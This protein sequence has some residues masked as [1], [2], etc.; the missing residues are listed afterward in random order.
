MAR[1]PLTNTEVP[2]YRETG[3]VA[4]EERF[5]QDESA[6]CTLQPRKKAQGLNA[7]AVGI[8][9]GE[10]GSVA[11]RYGFIPAIRSMQYSSAANPMFA[12]WSSCS[13]A[14]SSTKALSR[15]G[16]SKAD[17]VT[18]M[19]WPNRQP[20]HGQHISRRTN[21]KEVEVPNVK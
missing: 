12:L 5:D 9:E 4:V 2:Q 1:N 10:G 16:P 21:M 6:S 7:H 3:F 14:T 13:D 20:E 19:I 11:F 18:D 15:D 8:Y 17:S